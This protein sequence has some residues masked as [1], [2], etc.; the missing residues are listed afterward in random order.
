[1]RILVLSDSHG[2]TGAILKALADQPAAS[3]IIHLGDGERDFLDLA[4]P[5]SGRQVFQ[6]SGNCDFGALEPW[7]RIEI[8]QGVPFFLC[9]GHKYHVKT[10]LDYLFMETCKRK[11]KIALFG[12]THLAL[13]DYRNGVYLMNP[14]SVGKGT[15][16]SYGIVD[17]T[18]QGIAC[19][20]IPLYKTSSFSEK[21][22]YDRLD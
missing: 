14:G 1:M 4:G 10:G 15:Q 8:F 22:P 19:N 5:L 3:T 21:R 12:H 9:H 20:I 11:C 7:E 16:P 18:P 2:N 6:V 17:I 13:T